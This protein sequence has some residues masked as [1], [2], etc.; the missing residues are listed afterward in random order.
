M[1]CLKIIL[2]ILVIVFALINEA[3]TQW[4]LVI[5]GAILIILSVWHCCGHMC[6]CNEKTEIPK[7][8]G[9]K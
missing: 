5:V 9:K 8:K 2:G 6:K 1:H 3:W 7:K 4:A